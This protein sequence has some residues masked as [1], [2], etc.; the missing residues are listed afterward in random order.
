MILVT[1]E[2]VK[3]VLMEN[4]IHIYDIYHDIWYIS[5]I[6]T[7]IIYIK[8]TYIYVCI[9]NTKIIKNMLIHKVKMWVDK[10]PSVTYQ[11][12][13]VKNVNFMNLRAGNHYMYSLY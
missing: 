12:N 1:M 6:C 3:A 4:Y 13:K 10:S 9:I 2:T 8:H 11:E 5:C 7:S